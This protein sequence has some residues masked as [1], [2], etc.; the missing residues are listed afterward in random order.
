MCNPHV[1]DDV[2][3]TT[4]LVLCTKLKCFFNVSSNQLKL[5]L[6]KELK[7]PQEFVSLFMTIPIQ[8]S[9]FKLIVPVLTRANVFFY[10]T[11]LIYPVLLHLIIC[12]F[13]LYK[14]SQGIIL[15]NV[16]NCRIFSMKNCSIFLKSFDSKIS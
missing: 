2:D 8:Y 3:C 11:K 7:N 10:V 6:A 1:D 14:N 9:P 16:S 15:L 5:F 13:G 12:P 4:C